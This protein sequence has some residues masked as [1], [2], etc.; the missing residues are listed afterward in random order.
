MESCVLGHYGVLTTYFLGG[1]FS[2][3]K[4]TEWFSHAPEILLLCDFFLLCMF[5]FWLFLWFVFGA[6]RGSTQFCS[7]CKALWYVND[8]DG[9]VNMQMSQWRGLETSVSFWMSS[10]LE[11]GDRRVRPCEAWGREF[12][13]KGVSGGALCACELLRNCLFFNL[14]IVFFFQ[15]QVDVSVHHSPQA[16]WLRGVGL[17]LLQLHHCCSGETQNPPGQFGMTHTLTTNQ[18]TVNNCL[19]PWHSEWALGT[20]SGL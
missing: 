13:V 6:F 8:Q 7:S 10:P 9:L 4:K 19:M 15:V 1:F 16:I 11:F 20:S 5:F 18:L 12:Y 17:H 2:G 3:E 14:L